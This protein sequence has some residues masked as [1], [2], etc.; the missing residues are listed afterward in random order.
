MDPRPSVMSHP[1]SA[2]SSRV[3]VTGLGMVTSLG[4]TREECW[5][6]LREGRHG[7]RTLDLPAPNRGELSW[8]GGM[9]YPRSL[10]AISMRATAEAL[11]DAGLMLSGNG[12]NRDRVAVV[13]GLSKGNPSDLGRLL[14]SLQEHGPGWPGTRSWL[15]SWPHHGASSIS[16]WLD[17][18]GPC[19]APVAACATGLIAA[20]QAAELIRRGE[21]DVAIVGGADQ[22]LS[23]FLLGAFRRMGVLAGVEPGHD[24]GRAVRPWDK[25]R[26]GFLVGEGAAVL[27]L[28]REDH[29]RAR[30]ALPYAEFAGGASGADAFHMT[31]LDP[32]PSNLGGLIGRA[33]RRGGVDPSEIDHVNVHG[34]ATRSNDPLECQA[35][36]LALGEGA[37]GVSCSANKAQVGHC[38]GA[39]G[40]VELVFTCLAVRDQFVPPT[41]NLDDP[42]RLCDLDGTPHVGKARTIR[43][44]VKLSLGFGGHLA[45]AVL[46]RADEPR[47]PPVQAGPP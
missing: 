43:A 30:G 15:S 6:G 29:A 17:L 3:V 40:A 38:L 12:I 14:D 10:G 39:A 46:R 19:I 11:R 18:R 42:D 22:S 24:P 37:D 44:A 9:T 28:E 23:P 47:R 27:V 8:V 5:R 20:L 41:L 34:T 32:D 33:L 1:S 36:R 4:G 26:K 45:A 25:A 2:L 31:D 21:C 16:R 13:F 35:L 7:F